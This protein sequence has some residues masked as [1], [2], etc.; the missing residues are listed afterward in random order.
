MAGASV[1]DSL[2]AF[3]GLVPRIELRDD[4]DNGEEPTLGDHRGSTAASGSPVVSGGPDRAARLQLFGE[5]ARGGMGAVL[6]GRDVD[7]GRDLAVKVLLEPLSHK[8]ELVRRFVEEAQIAGQLQHPG[9]VPVYELG[10]FVDRRPFF[11]MKLVKGRTL[12][13]MLR[14]RQVRSPEEG[15]LV[16]PANRQSGPPPVEFPLGVR[17]KDLPRFLDIFESICQTMA[18]AHARGVIHRDLKPANIMVG[19]FGEVQVM[20][21]GLAKVLSR[22]GVSGDDLARG[23]WTGAEESGETVI[24]TARSVSDA[25]ASR[26]GGVLGTPGY[27][28]PEQA[29]GELE[30]VDERAD[31]FGLGA[32]LCEVLTEQPAFVGR[33]AAETLQKAARGDLAEAFARLNDCGTDRDLIALARDCLAPEREDRPRHAGLVAERI[34][35]YL[36]GVQERLRRA[37]LARV[38]ADARAQEESKRRRLALALAAAVVALLA[39]GGTGAAVYVQ[40]RRDQTSRLELALRDVYLLREQA[41]PTGDPA[42]WRAIVAAATRAVDL[43]GPLVDASLSREALALQKDVGAAAEIADRD[44]ALLSTVM[45]I[46]ADKS[47]DPTGSAG[48]AAYAKAFR[49]AA[50]DI[51]ALGPDAAAAKIRA[52][53][54]GEVPVI[55]AALDDWS[56]RRRKARTKDARGL[57]LLTATARAADPDPTRNRLRAIWLQPI[58]AQQR[59]PLLAL[60]KDADPRGWPVQTVTLLASSLL[61]ANEPAAA[62][63]LLDRAWPH[64]PDDVWI[65]HTLGNALEQVQPPRTDDAIRFYTAA[66]ALRPETAH[67]LAHAL[68]RRGRGHEAVVVF[69]NLTELLPEIGWHWG[70]LA[71]LCEVRG[72]HSEAVAAMERAV[73]RFRETLSLR[74]DDIAPHVNLGLVLCDVAHDYPAAAAE[75]REVLRLDPEHTIAHF[76]LGNVLRYQGKL[77]EAVRSYR[78][79]IRIKPDFAPAH[80]NLAYILLRQGNVD[81]AIAESR[82]SLRL[83]P[84]S[85]LVP[86]H[87]AWLLAA[88]PDRPP[89]DYAEAAGLVRKSLETQSKS[90]SVHTILALVEYRFGHWDSAIAAVEQ[91]MALRKGEQA[92]NSFLLAMA[93]ARKGEKGKALDWFDKAVERTNTLKF[94][95]VDVDLLWSEAARLLGRPGPPRAA[96][97]I[98]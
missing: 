91:S 93:L 77:D 96:P 21:W 17:I 52:R 59:E 30:T 12:A 86:S 92:G 10:T 24:A 5:I 73:A 23:D 54:A 2:T 98:P 67:D 84:D 37:E 71:T 76:G 81:R 80:H 97:A 6:K 65:N 28:S 95:D 42:K 25:E 63:E 50:I 85:V 87:V 55:A 22:D 72:N 43:I 31:V 89:R 47:K 82:E 51:D 7:L 1:L 41:K 46:R 75:Y 88:Y 19:S 35:A 66:R 64:H 62:A 49:D 74:P 39:V 14:A 26:A 94:K 20:D 32:I 9:V 38:E 27:M 56:A 69:R 8:P 16:R 45:D 13:E 36:T 61:E 4:G 68:D 70:C 48:D 40:H 33:G 57:S 53:L 60:A 29:R 34:T 18:Y 78:E 83:Q 11:T 3:V 44:A 90:P 79:A 15:D 58:T